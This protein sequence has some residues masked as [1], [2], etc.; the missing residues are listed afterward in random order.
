M[1]KLTEPKVNLEA[2]Y[3]PK[4][5]AA[6][7]GVNPSTLYRWGKAGK[8]KQTVIELTNRPAYLGSDILQ[9]WRS[10]Y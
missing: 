9:A 2:R 8:I 7:L 6:V 5:A 10:I 4:K 1:L 3:T